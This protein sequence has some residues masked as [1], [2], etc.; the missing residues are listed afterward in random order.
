[1]SNAIHNYSNDKRGQV[2]PL[3]K[4]GSSD[5]NTIKKHIIERVGQEAYAFFSTYVDPLS[6]STFIVSTTNDFNITNYPKHI[7]SLVNLSKV[8]NTRYINKFFEKVNSKLDIGGTYIVCFESIQSRKEKHSLGNIPVI[9]NLWFAFEFIFLRMFPKIWGLKKIY[10]LVT[11]GRNRLLSKA[12]VMGRLVSCGFHIEATDAFGTLSYVV[13]KKI[14]DPEFNMNVSY[15]P[16]FKMNR[17]GKG[18][19]TI[20]VYKLR[21]MH[22]YAEYLQDYVLKLNGYADTGKPKNDFR[23]TPWGRFLRKYWLDELP[24]LLNVL[25]GDLKLVGVRPISRRYFQDIP[26]DLQELRLK[27]KPGCIPPYVALNRNGDVDSVLQAEREYL[28]QKIR[29]PHTT[30]IQ[31]FFKAVFNIIF[32]RKRSA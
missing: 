14:K 21:T 12:E 31:F 30:D 28:N 26:K 9:K 16:L 27:L 15:G 24:Q 17:I 22:P 7:D 25:K 11:R 19:K 6:E 20:K 2:I 8:N 23:L 10:F 18:G 4:G 1:V 29:K 5:P 13:V 32:K 3:Y